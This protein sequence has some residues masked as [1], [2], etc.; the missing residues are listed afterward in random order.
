MKV[1]E[2]IEKLVDQE[3]NELHVALPAKIEEYDPEKMRV[4]VT[5]LAKKELEGEEVTIPPI[6][7]V[8]IAH[9]NAGSFVIRPPYSKGDVVQV[10]FNE[11]ALDKLIIT[12][13]PES[14]EYTRTHSLD[15][16][17]V[18][19]GLK[20]E[21]EANLPSSN[22][23]DFLIMNQDTNEKVIMKK[24]GNIILETTNLLKLGSDGASEGVLLGDVVKAYLDGHTHPY[25][26][27][28]DPG[29]GNTGSP[30]QSCPDPS[31]KVKVE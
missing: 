24:A 22:T 23:E 20:T 17:V 26:W 2:L 6:V 19:S 14:V 5:L 21:Q 3:L 10:L 8:P 29:S 15:D 18:I 13:D 9:F 4:K 27:G 11:R 16:A 31:S 28:H 25:T 30:N 7:E 12:G 1:N